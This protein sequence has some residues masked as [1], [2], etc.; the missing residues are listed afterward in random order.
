MP[1]YEYRCECGNEVEV[2]LSCEEADQSQACGC[3]EVMQRKMS[4]SSFV[5]K[6]TGN[7]MVLD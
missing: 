2:R 7:G 3:G 6:Q 1:I 4:V 5:M